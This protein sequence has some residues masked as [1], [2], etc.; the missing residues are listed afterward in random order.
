MIEARVAGF[1]VGGWFGLYGPARMEPAL[2]ARL[3]DAA[4]K[5]VASEALA[6]RFLDQGYELW[7]G[8]AELLA[9]KGVS[10]RAL[11]AT[12]SQGIEAD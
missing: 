10:D 2:V 9:R 1:D 7:T 5:A 11:W 4:R 3:N 6:A 8:S 12:A